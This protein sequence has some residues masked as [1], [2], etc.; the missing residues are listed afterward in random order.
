MAPTS[1]L[2]GGVL[3]LADQQIKAIFR[4][5]PRGELS[6]R[7]LDVLGAGALR[8]GSF[9]LVWLLGCFALAA[10]ANLVTGRDQPGDEATWRHDSY[11]RARERFGA[12]LVTALITFCAFLVAVAAL[13]FIELTIMRSVGWSR[14]ARFN[15]LAAS[16]IIIVSA[17]VVSWLG[18]AIPLIIRSE[19]GVWAALE[20]SIELS[21]GYEA[22]LFLLVVESVAGSY[23]AWYVTLYCMSLLIPDPLKHMYWY[24]WAVNLVGVLVSTAIESPLFI[25]FSLLSDPGLVSPPLLPRLQQSA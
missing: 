4:G 3:I 25:G 21:N 8:Y 2:S 10:I 15:Y 20:K 1:L 23:L 11:Q 22:A 9:F 6:S 5:I 13:G 16:I 19:I 7:F 17:S 12:L 18:V 14:F 24:A